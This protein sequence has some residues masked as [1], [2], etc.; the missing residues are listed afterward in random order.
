MGFWDF[1]KSVGSDFL[2]QAKRDAQKLNDEEG[3]RARTLEDS[4]AYQHGR[5]D[6][7]MAFVLSTP[8]RKEQDAGHPAAGQTG[9]NIS[10]MLPH[11]HKGNPAKFPSTDIDDYPII[12]SVSKPRWKSP[13][14]SRTEGT[15]AE[16]RDKANVERLA[17]SFEGI[18]DAVAF[19]RNG[20]T[21]TAASGF[22][23][24]VADG[25]PHASNQ[26]INRTV[27]ASG[28]TRRQRAEERISKVAKS[29]LSKM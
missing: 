8:G 21:A 20:Q 25:L 18:K 26:A 16:I 7:T 11:L 3:S 12:N 28:D 5:P 29:V 19:G 27:P 22:S 2:E 1:V 15:K 4:P 23:G 17:K 24:K 9:K 10:K 13:T 6:I 14:S